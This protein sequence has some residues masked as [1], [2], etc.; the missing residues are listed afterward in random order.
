MSK[1]V[2]E[3]IKERKSVR[4]YTKEPLSVELVDNIN[5]YI[6]SL[7]DPLGSKAR[8]KWI[9]T[10]MGDQPVKLGTYGIISGAK[11]FLALVIEKNNQ[12]SEIG[13]GY[14]F[15]QAILY[16]T[17]LGLG[18]CWLGA[19]F[20]SN[21]FLQ[22]IELKD[23][24]K[25]AIISPVGYKREKKSFLES[26]MRKGAGSDHR[27]AFG[28][29]FFLG[30]FDVPLQKDKAGRFATPLEMVRLAPSASNKQ[31]WRVVKEEDR[32]HFYHLPNRFSL[33]DMGI[34]FCHFEQTCKEQN[35]NG[36]FKTLEGIPSIDKFEYC[37][38]W[39]PE[40]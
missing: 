38:S 36:C 15:E 29:L 11:H 18:T 21:D 1:S 23:N 22:L 6:K 34:A 31:P 30:S 12:L 16:C 28:S 3:I 2:I 27:K 4:S 13:G 33:Y 35:L 20:N 5:S 8:I 7:V 26:V 19:T 37:M 24:E 32:F 17:A 25:L 10:D 39:I 14:L 40:E 9:S